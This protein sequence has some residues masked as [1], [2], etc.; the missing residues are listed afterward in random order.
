[1][2][3]W[4]AN[5]LA[6]NGYRIIIC[7]L[8]RSRAQTLARRKGYRFMKNEIGAVGLAD[9]VVIA[10]PTQTTGKTIKQIEPH[11]LPSTLLIEIS[12][13]KEPLRR[14]IEDMIRRGR[15]VLSIH[16]MFGPGAKSLEGKTV[17]VAQQ[18]KKNPAAKKILATFKKKGARIVYSNLQTHDK[19]ISATLALPHFLNF[20]FI[21]TLREAGLPPNKM[22][23][24]GGTTFGL[25]LLV[26]EALYHENLQNEAAIL[27]NDDSSDL[28][29]KFAA[30]AN[31]LRS[32]VSRARREELIRNLRNSAAYVRRDSL[33]D[34]AYDRFI[35]AAEAS[36]AS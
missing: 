36:A 33:F 7:D 10:T 18:P 14:T 21:E 32:K 27:L 1:M 11:L 30:Q 26:A 34:S 24:F 19:I 8:Q 28:L 23:E 22:R 2:G 6:T 25:Q 20:A 5:F 4:M 9:A 3:A 16:P 29:K 15:A 13:V 35:A 17:I 31:R 12:S